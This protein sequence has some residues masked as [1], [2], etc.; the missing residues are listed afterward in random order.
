MGALNIFVQE[1]SGIV[2]GSP[3]AEESVKTTAQGAITLLTSNPILLIG[4][5]IVI[6]LIV[7]LLYNYLTQ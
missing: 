6:L 3:L 1:E 4:V 7:Y 2:G 5:I